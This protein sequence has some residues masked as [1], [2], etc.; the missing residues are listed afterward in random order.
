[1]RF[2]VP[3]DT[4]ESRPLVGPVLRAHV[5]YSEARAVRQTLV[6]LLALVAVATC[7]IALFPIWWRS[8]QRVLIEAVGALLLCALL[9]GLDEWLCWR[10]R[11]RLLAQIESLSEN[12]SDAGRRER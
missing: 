6:V 11:E 3:P 1:M 5:R 2:D 12:R 4:P 8:Y 7:A 10:R 9:A